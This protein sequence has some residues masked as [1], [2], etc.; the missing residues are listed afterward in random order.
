M[1]STVGIWMN[2]EQNQA[3]PLKPVHCPLLLL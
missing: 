3:F 2:A 1:L